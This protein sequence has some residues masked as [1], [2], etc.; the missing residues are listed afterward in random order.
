M[1]ITSS[2][3]KLA[4]DWKLKIKDWNLN[5]PLLPNLELADGVVVSEDKGG[6]YYDHKTDF[7]RLGS[8]PFRVALQDLRKLHP[9]ANL[10][11]VFPYNEGKEIV[12]YSFENFK[13][14]TPTDKRSG[15]GPANL[16]FLFNSGEGEKFIDQVRSEPTL[17][18][19]LIKT[20]FPQFAEKVEIKPW[21]ELVFLPQDFN[22]SGIKDK[23]QIIA[24][25]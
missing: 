8:V 22:Y 7:G 9:D 3:D 25:R 24:T 19:A 17:P 14:S 18:D 5:A 11:A 2:A 15:F 1:E 23:P 6:G 10:L 21:K 20:K 13:P 16:Y 12:W 4:Q